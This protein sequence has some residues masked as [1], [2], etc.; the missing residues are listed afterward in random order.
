MGHLMC[1]ALCTVGVSGHTPGLHS[2][3][4]TKS[5]TVETTNVF[6]NHQVCPGG[7]ETPL[8]RLLCISQLVGLREK[9]HRACV[10]LQHQIQLDLPKVSIL[11]K[12]PLGGVNL[13]TFPPFLCDTRAK[14]SFAVPAPLLGSCSV[15]SCF[16][17]AWIS[18]DYLVPL[19]SPP[20]FITFLS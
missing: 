16:H 13:V 10:H 17:R 20:G 15:R 7:W 5:Q 12:K 11:F 18:P 3:K 8:C 9:L 6:R 2:K 1:G 4:G 19:S 14:T